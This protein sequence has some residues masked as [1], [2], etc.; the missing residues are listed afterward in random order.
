[1]FSLFELMFRHTCRVGAPKVWRPRSGDLFETR[2]CESPCQQRHN[3][4][5]K[6]TWGWHHAVMIMINRTAR[7]RM[8]KNSSVSP[9]YYCMRT[10]RNQMKITDSVNSTKNHER[11]KAIL[12]IYCCWLCYAGL[13][14]LLH[15][16]P[17]SL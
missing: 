17:R 11:E 16:L 10:T 14:I 6:C 8:R 12:P 5:H 13:A 9:S 2:P 7:E 3:T 15:R 1:M 4:Y